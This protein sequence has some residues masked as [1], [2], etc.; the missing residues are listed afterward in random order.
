MKIQSPEINDFCYVFGWLC[1]WMLPNL[2]VLSDDKSITI[3]I[4]IQKNL[5]LEN[6]LN[7]YIRKELKKLGNYS[8]TIKQRLGRAVS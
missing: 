8:L 2:I 3:L 6:Q 4:S 7:T 1:Y 5:T